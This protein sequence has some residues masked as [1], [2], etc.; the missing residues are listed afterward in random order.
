[1]ST[2][3]YTVHDTVHDTLHHL[4]LYDDIVREHELGTLRKKIQA[5]IDEQ[6]HW[7]QFEA[8]WHN[9]N[10]THTIVAP[11]VVRERHTSFRRTPATYRHNNDFLLALLR[12]A[13]ER[14]DYA[15]KQRTRNIE[16]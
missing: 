4:K 10:H 12:D 16:P 14:R 9:M 6:L 1:M 11:T 7:G 5:A 13:Q 15:L 2:N 8:W 3:S